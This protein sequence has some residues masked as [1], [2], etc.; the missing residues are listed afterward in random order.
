MGMVLAVFIALSLISTAVYLIG[1]WIESPTAA[2][3]ESVSAFTTTGASLLE[4]TSSLPGWLKVFR[5]AC[6]WIGGGVTL[7]FLASIVSNTD[8]S[9]G[10]L[11]RSDSA[12]SALYRTGIRFTSIAKR[13]L[14]TYLIMTVV[15]IIALY[16]C[17]FTVLGSLCVSLSTVSTGG[18]LPAGFIPSGMG[19][20]VTV[21]F[22]I[23]TC[24]NYTLY[25]HAIKKHFDRFDTNSELY[26]LVFIIAGA[27][28]LVCAN[29]YF[30]GTY[31]LR[32]SIENGIFNSVSFM[33]TTG[34]TSADFSAWPP[35]AKAIL[36]ALSFIGG[37]SCSLGSGIKLMRIIVVFRII[38]KSFTS[39]IHTRAVVTTRING[40]RLPSE[41][42]SSIGTFFLTYFT[43]YL[44]G[45]F[46]I[47]FESQDIISCFTVSAALLNNT[48]AAV[49]SSISYA[50]V[51]PVMHILMSVLMLAGRLELYT[52]LLPFSR[53]DKF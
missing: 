46:V 35:F 15:Q 39:R 7:V 48:G 34:F 32:G 42:A 43:F 8:S 16:L 33:T 29:L 28:I 17:G 52:V 38:S 51:S 23:F 20:T 36:T 26:A 44:A 24:V 4:D 40:R 9:S 11:L 49:E 6:Q 1:G 14:L 47:S 3:F 53:I 10:G 25:Y 30:T 12:S 50:G 41:A 19:E 13:L 18:F 31:D 5:C 22:M 27:S 45:A 2:F 37:S 21:L